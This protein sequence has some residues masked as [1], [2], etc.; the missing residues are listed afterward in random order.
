MAEPNS[1]KFCCPLGHSCGAESCVGYTIGSS[2]YQY[3]FSCS[4]GFFPSKLLQLM[5]LSA[6]PGY[7]DTNTVLL[8]HFRSCCES[9]LQLH[10]LKEYG[11]P[12]FCVVVKISLYNFSLMPRPELSWTKPK[13]QF[14]TFYYLPALHLRIQP[15]QQASFFSSIGFVC[16]P[17][18][19]CV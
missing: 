7:L 19:W 1:A 2:S 5:P 8:H 18:I 17:A 14:L 3:T 9:M 13:W 15:S 12:S 4:K 10:L 6:L 16:R 11:S